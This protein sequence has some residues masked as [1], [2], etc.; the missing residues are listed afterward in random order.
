MEEIG[1]I[2][3]GFSW[4][5]MFEDFSNICQVHSSFIK[6]WQEWQVLHMTTFVRSDYILS[7]T[8]YNDKYFH[9]CRENQRTQFIFSN[10][11]EIVLYTWLRGKTWSI[12]TGHKWQYSTTHALCMRDN[13]RYR[14]TRRKCNNYCFSTATIVMR[15]RL[16]VTFIRTLPPLFV[17]LR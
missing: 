10:V 4:Y 5:V 14:L 16:N 3:N 11:S 13:R 9:S 8:S 2:L 6:I 17:L 12:R 15:T 7:N 1:S